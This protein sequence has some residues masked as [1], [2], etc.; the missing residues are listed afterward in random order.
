MSGTHQV[1]FD[2]TADEGVPWV[3]FSELQDRHRD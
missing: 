1:A 2:D 3:C